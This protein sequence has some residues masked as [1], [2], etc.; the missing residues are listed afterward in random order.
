MK[1]IRSREESMKDQR[2]K[3][4]TLWNKIEKEERK[5]SHSK[6]PELVEQKLKEFHKELEKIEK[7]SIEGNKNFN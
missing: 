5:A 1:D 4:E 2:I 7:E 3:K 6:H